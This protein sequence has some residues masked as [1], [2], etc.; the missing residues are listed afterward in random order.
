[1]NDNNYRIKIK[2]G[3]IEFEVE[4]DKEFVKELFEEFKTEMEEISESK[5]KPI[6]PVIAKKEQIQSIYD[7]YTIKQMYKKL[8]PT[9]NLDRIL[10]FAYWLLKAEDIKEFSISD[11]MK[12]FDQFSLRRPK[13]PPRD[14]RT[15]VNPIKGYLNTC[16]KDGYY[17]L[18]YDGIQYIQEKL[19]SLENK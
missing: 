19:N 7:K 5:M 2:K 15:L 6:Q 10:V 13:N 14:F 12:Y 11:I 4:G 16:S 1:M 8:N 9:T 18:S 17:S 3:D